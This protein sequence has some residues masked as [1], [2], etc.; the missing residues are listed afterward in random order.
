MPRTPTGSCLVSKVLFKCQEVMQTHSSKGRSSE[1][2][3]PT[4]AV[5]PRPGGGVGGGLSLR[6]VEATCP[7]G[8]QGLGR[9]CPARRPWPRALPLAW[10]CASPHPLSRGLPSPPPAQGWFRRPVSASLAQRAGFLDVSLL[11]PILDVGPVCLPAKVLAQ[12]TISK[13]LQGEG[14]F[15][16]ALS[17]HH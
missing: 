14:P 12:Q 15:T 1:Q 3:H 4:E 8:A 10:P 7:D 17:W 13:Y 2:G 6:T 9:P 16:G 5:G 11:I